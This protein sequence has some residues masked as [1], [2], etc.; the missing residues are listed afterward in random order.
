M[1]QIDSL[2]WTPLH[3]AVKKGNIEMSRVL[4]EGRTQTKCCVVIQWKS[5]PNKRDYFWRTP[6]FLAVSEGNLP[7]VKL[8][9]CFKAY[10]QIAT[11]TG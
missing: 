4:L 9:L 10:P 8:L 5:D 2:G 11:K 1:H 3:W 6:L 7:M